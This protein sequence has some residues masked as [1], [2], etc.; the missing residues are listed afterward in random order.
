MGRE[1]QEAHRLLSEKARLHQW[2]LPEAAAQAWLA[3]LSKRVAHY[4]NFALLTFHLSEIIHYATYDQV[5]QGIVP[6]RPEYSYLMD[7]YR[8]TALKKHEMSA[9]PWLQSPD[10]TF[11]EK[12]SSYKCR[13]CK[14][15]ECT[16]QALQTRSAD[17]PTSYYYQCKN[18][19]CKHTFKDR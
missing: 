3:E 5:V 6:I 8:S 12:I 4:Q 11:G 18:P 9:T 17:E 10:E 14:V 1:L 16:M 19:D 15:G 2:E 13:K 7:L